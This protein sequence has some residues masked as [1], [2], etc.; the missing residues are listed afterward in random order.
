MV[1]LPGRAMIPAVLMLAAACDGPTPLEPSAAMPRAALVKASSPCPLPPPP[2]TSVLQ[3]ESYSSGPFRSLNSNTETF[4]TFS[5]ATCQN[6]S[7]IWYDFGGIPALYN[8][9]A[10]GQSYLQQ[11]YLTHP[12]IVVGDQTGPLGIFLPIDRPATVY[13]EEPVGLPR[14]FPGTAGCNPQGFQLPP[15]AQVPG[16]YITVC[17]NVGF[18]PLGWLAIGSTKDEI[19]CGNGIPTVPSP[20]YQFFPNAPNAYQL[21]RYSD[22]LIG[23]TM[24]V[25]GFQSNTLPA[26]WVIV[27][28]PPSSIPNDP[29]GY[30]NPNIVLQGGGVITIR[31]TS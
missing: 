29:C 4:I 5:N 13:I 16:R 14:C 23:S 2:T 18:I 10:P 3:S 28:Q 25:C 15:G 20:G 30:S 26:G 6:V 12:W 21:E 11:T 27:P 31:R 24:N 1:T 9:L 7:I 19:Q 17:M 8:V 22:Q